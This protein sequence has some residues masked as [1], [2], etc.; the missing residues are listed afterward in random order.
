MTPDEFHTALHVDLGKPQVEVR[1]RTAGL[2][3]GSRANEFDVK[4]LLWMSKLT[5]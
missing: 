1:T 4:C 2:T 5:F 3:A